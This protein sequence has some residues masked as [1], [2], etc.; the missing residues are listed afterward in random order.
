MKGMKVKRRVKVPKICITT[1][2]F[3]RREMRALQ[4]VGRAFQTYIWGNKK[5]GDDPSGVGG[6]A[7]F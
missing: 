4:A 1:L 7:T 5:N 2:R 6:A 3:M